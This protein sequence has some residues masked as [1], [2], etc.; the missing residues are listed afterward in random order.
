MNLLKTTHI[1]ETLQN[2]NTD[3]SNKEDKGDKELNRTKKY[4]FNNNNFNR[5]PMDQVLNTYEDNKSKSESESESKSKSENDSESESISDSDSE[6]IDNNMQTF[7]DIIYCIN[8]GMNGHLYKKC[9]EPITSYGIILI[10][11]DISDDLKKKFIDSVNNYDNFVNNVD[12]INIKDTTIDIGLFSY[13]KSCISFLMVQRKHTLGFIEFMRGRYSIDNIDDISYLFK[14]MTSEE[15]ERIKDESFDTLWNNLWGKTRNKS[16]FKNEYINSNKKFNKLKYY[17][18]G[19]LNLDYYVDKIKPTWDYAEWGF[20]KG[21]R[22]YLESDIECSIREFREETG[23][24]NDD[25]IIFNNVKPTIELFIGTNGVPYKHVYYT[26]II[27]TDKPMF[28]DKL[29]PYQ[30]QEIGN[31]KFMSYEECMSIIRPYHIEKKK[32][33]SN[34]YMAIINMLVNII[35]Q[36]IIE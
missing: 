35:K 6:S 24:L 36:D 26:G 21:R 27:D 19:F 12:G 3:L 33:I 25:F 30:Y 31:I 18:G 11:L 5:T 9:N 20:P 1:F 32:I 4:N 22:N 10:S 34:I 15:I 29:N 23:L 13:V 16:N 2:N 7:K 17:Q 28:V 14:Q 8:C